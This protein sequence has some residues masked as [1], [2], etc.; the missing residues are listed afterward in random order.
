MRIGTLLGQSPTAADLVAQARV[1]ARLGFDSLWT[2]QHPGRWDPLGVLAA[3]SGRDIGVSEV[4]TAIVPTYPRHPVVTATQALT[5]R[6]FDGAR[7]T[8]GIGP[9]HA[10]HI[11]DQLGLPYQR[12]ARH[13]REYLEVLR[14]LLR[15]EH[16]RHQGPFFTVDAQLAVPADPPAVLV[17]AL[18][19]R[20]LEVARE[21][22]DGTIAVWVR[23]DT[24]A[25]HLVPR[26]G[27]SARVVVTVLVAVTDDADAARESVAR[28]FAAVADMPAYRAVL[29]RGGLS[30]PA[31]TVVAGTEEQVAREL[32]RFRDA[33]ATDLVVSALGTAPERERVLEV[34]TGLR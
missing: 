18:G 24:V 20:M 28:D 1:A 29:D 5:L 31:D 23:P 22:A 13:T 27:D 12:P 3:L 7:L 9:S 21:L 33:G 17:S 26:L 19:P 11:T 4:G 2:N 6:A 32:G 10:W 15:G 16:V 30:G 8:L 25:E 34:V 14:P